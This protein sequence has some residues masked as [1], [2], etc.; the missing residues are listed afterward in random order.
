MTTRFDDGGPEPGPDDPLAVI[1]RP[2]SDHLAPPLGRYES[3][4]RGAARR[5]LLRAAAG[6]GLSCAV[7]ALAALPLLRTS[8]A[9][10][11]PTPPLAPPPATSPSTPPAPST[12]PSTSPDSA[13]PSAPSPGPSS[14]QP[15]AETPT[16]A[17]D[18][19]SPPR[20]STPTS[21]PTADT[22]APA[23]T[24]YLPSPT[25]EQRAVPSETR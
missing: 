1:L 8:D 11:S 9:P 6:A 13:N 20:T 16:D 14:P 4:R 23:P 18:V 21:A 5:R 10:A 24:S 22:A 19:P 3:I 15:T 2:P 7:A 25:V 17:S 12:P